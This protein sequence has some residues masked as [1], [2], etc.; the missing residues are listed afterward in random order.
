MLTPDWNSRI[1]LSRLGP[2]APHYLARR[3]RDGTI[4]LEPCEVV[5]VSELR[6]LRDGG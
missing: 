1:S 5:S 6:R 4:V 3:E 2:V